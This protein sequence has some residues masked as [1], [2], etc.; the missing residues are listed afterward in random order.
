MNRARVLGLLVVLGIAAVSWALTC[1]AWRLEQEVAR[2]APLEPASFEA[3]TLLALG[4]GGAHENPA[5][6][7][8]ATAVGLGNR[9]VVVDAGRA[10]ADALRLS[11]IPVS[12][13]DTVLLTNLLPE[14]TV[15]LD[16][17]L[18]AGWQSA[19]ETPVRL[20]GPPGTAALADGLERGH[21]PGAAAL[22]DQLGL[23]EGGARFE[24]VEIDDGWSEERDGLVIRA[25][26]LPGGP[27]P[28]LAYRFEA[29]DG[30]AV[31]AGTG[32][33][34]EALVEL[35]R[36]ADVLVHG[37]V[38]PMTARLADQL[39]LEPGEAERLVGESALQT[40]IE[41][42]G[43]IAERARVGT[44]VLV[45]L[46]PPPVFDFQLSGLVDFS[47]RLVIPEDGEQVWP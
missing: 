22:G 33:G 34:T 32:W 21:R 2:V 11:G 3:L 25:A 39:G 18:F 41:D 8:P 31:V 43:G 38:F 37:A 29:A 28:A 9:V 17:L 27:L 36:G 42:V 20:V 5:R 40:P 45:R 14:N 23:P 46:Q 10:L 47:G 19:R 16:D 15:G 7:G 4:T 44:L 35:A 13:P 30:A 1:G 26:E 6:R 24:A 12:Q